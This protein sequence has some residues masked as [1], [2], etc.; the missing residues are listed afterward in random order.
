[1][2]ADQKIENGDIETKFGSPCVMHGDPQ[3]RQIF[4]TKIAAI[5]NR[6]TP[7]VVALVRVTVSPNL[8]SNKSD[9]YA[10]PLARYG[11]TVSIN[12]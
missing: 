12:R 3:M 1:M 2:G 6:L 5:K 4:A 9:A 7:L 8:F 11:A 10:K